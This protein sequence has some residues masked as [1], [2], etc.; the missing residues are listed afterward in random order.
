MK[1]KFYGDLLMCLILAQGFYWKRL[2]KELKYFESKIE[3]DGRQV[4]IYLKY[5]SKFIIY[6]NKFR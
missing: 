3:D 4:G 1:P 2:N 6:I 5:L